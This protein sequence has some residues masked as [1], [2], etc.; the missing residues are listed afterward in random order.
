MPNER[1]RTPPKTCDQQRRPVCPGAPTHMRPTRSLS[2]LL[3][4]AYK[5]QLV[6]MPILAKPR[7]S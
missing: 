2:V 4:L 7:R 3:K 1:E 6:G 5:F